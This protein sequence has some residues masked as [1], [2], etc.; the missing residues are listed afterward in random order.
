MAV[1]KKW[2]KLGGAPTVLMS[3][4]EVVCTSKLV[5]SLRIKCLQTTVYTLGTVESKKSDTQTVSLI[6]ENFGNTGC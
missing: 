4:E 2:G 3:W 1:G 5:Y 6:V